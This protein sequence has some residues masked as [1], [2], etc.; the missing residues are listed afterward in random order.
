MGEYGSACFEGLD[1]TSGSATLVGIFAAY[2]QERWHT[3]SYET[4]VEWL[5]KKPAE[6]MDL[7]SYIAHDAWASGPGPEQQY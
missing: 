2:M 3:A 4:L 6:V 1:K 7:L 5:T